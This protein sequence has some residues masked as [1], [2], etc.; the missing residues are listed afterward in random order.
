MSESKVKIHQNLHILEITNNPKYLTL[1]STNKNK[2]IHSYFFSDNNIPFNTKIDIINNELHFTVESHVNKKF[3][4]KFF[5]LEQLMEIHKVFR[6]YDK[7]E[8]CLEYFDETLN[9]TIN[10]PTIAIKED[11]FI[12]FI[13]INVNQLPKKNIS[14][15]IKLEIPF[16]KLFSQNQNE[17]INLKNS[18]DLKNNID[19]SSNLIQELIL[20]IDYLTRDNIEMHK[21]IDILEKNNIEISKNIEKSENSI[22]LLEDKYKNVFSHNEK[23]EKNDLNSIEFI[24]NLKNSIEFGQE[25]PKFIM[26]INSSNINIDNI[27]NKNNN[28]D[29][30][31]INI[32]Q[33]PSIFTFKNNN[34]NIENNIKNNLN[35][36]IIN[37]NENKNKKEEENNEIINVINFF[38]S[39]DHKKNTM[40]IDENEEEKKNI[41]IENFDN[42][43]K[44]GWLMNNNYDLMAV[45]EPASGSLNNYPYLN[46]MQIDFN[47]YKRKT[48]NP[49]VSLNDIQKIDFCKGEARSSGKYR[50]LL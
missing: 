32:D 2:C 7:I 20:K 10:S 33:S 19:V 3:Y 28:E 9:N 11:Y 47:K 50:S 39:N 29:H 49:V 44:I 46:E 42:S 14:D 45:Q 16:V 23:K 6:M 13:K 35:M 12:L 21:R 38:E 8:D 26:K 4:E 37:N 18:F 24:D 40:V 36:I 25:S 1:K 15:T 43:K 34:M 30:M 17:S 27:E 48:C 41:N 22:K 31:D 5:S